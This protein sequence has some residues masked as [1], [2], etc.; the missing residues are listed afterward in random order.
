MRTLK[1]SEKLMAKARTPKQLAWA[2]QYY[3]DFLVESGQKTK[4]DIERLKDAV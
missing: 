4:E 3:F 2:I 1:K